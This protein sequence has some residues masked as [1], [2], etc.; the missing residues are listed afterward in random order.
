MENSKTKSS[1]KV[2]GMTCAMCAGTVEKRL[3]KLPGVERAEVNLNAEKANIDYDA[4]QTGISDF[5][6]AIK[7]AGYGTDVETVSFKVGGMSCVKCA[8]AVEKALGSLAGVVSAEVNA[9]SGKAEIEYVSGS[10]EADDMKKAVEKA[11]FQFLGLSGEA[12]APDSDA[13]YRQELQRKKIRFY[14]GI[15]LGL[16]LMLIKHAGFD[17]GLPQEY[18]FF[19]VSTPVFLFVSFP[20]FKAGFRALIK[21]VLNMDVM[22]SLG[23]GAAYLSSVMGT[24]RILLTGEFMFYD[25]ALMLAGFLTLGRY[26]EER[27]K[28]KTSESIKKLIALKP[29]RATLIKENNETKI[30]AEEV[31][32]GDILKIKAGDKIPV[33]GVVLDGESYVD[34]AMITGEPIPAFKK[35]EHSVIGGTINQNGVLKMRATRV[36]SDT[37]LAQIIRLVEEAQSSKPPIQ[38]FAD[39]VVSYFIPVILIIALSVSAAW[40]FL[41][42]EPLI[43]ALNTLIAVLVTACP[44]ALGLATPTAISVG[45]G[46]GAELGILIKNAETLEISSDISVVLFD[47]T[48][49]LTEGK[50]V[51]ADIESYGTD[52]N[53][54][55]GLAASIEKDAGHPL[56]AAI[57]DEA[58]RRQIELVEAAEVEVTG[59]KG[60]KG[61]VY[62]KAV[63]I[64]NKAWMDEN[65]VV[66]PDKALER[67]EAMNKEN[68]T[69]VWIVVDNY[70]TGLIGI[71]DRIKTGADSAVNELKKMGIRTV[72]LTGDDRQTAQAVGSRLNIDEIQSN[73]MPNDKAEIVKRFQSDG[74]KVAF[75]G[76]G[77][78][79]SPALTQADF[80]IALGAGSDIAVESGDMVLVRNDIKDAVAAVQLGKKVMTRIKQN[81]FWAFAYNSALIPLAA[82]ILYPVWKITFRPE[83]AGLAMAMSSVTVVSLSLL[84][85][86]YIPPAKK[87]H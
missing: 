73:V 77:I 61:R 67:A 11:G 7:D 53:E 64:G 56:G 8:Q 68:K 6:E 74:L 4:S 31:K 17:L 43:F 27:A 81:V 76:D 46:R 63:L 78:N 29:Q 2:R 83:L 82:G 5:V 48:G 38:K 21:G 80:G 37:T 36:G 32:E 22:Y 58:R 9:V 47:K 52:E 14:S 69:L 54:M 75:I 45:V 55:L 70:L 18:L 16:V 34:E 15:V 12:V 28:A 13:Q 85:K 42:G 39:K 33:D 84:L 3:S 49:T 59:G 26:L 41:F 30:P 79:D 65:N 23:M 60:I 1:L 10:I 72:M 86:R 25:T 19:I 71:S 35:A 57:V 50:P 66:V 40:L 62:G 44:C 87:R 51:V 20:I 24:F